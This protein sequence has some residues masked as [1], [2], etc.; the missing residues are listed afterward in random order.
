MSSIEEVGGALADAQASLPMS[1]VLSAM[2]TLRAVESRYADLLETAT[3]EPSNDIRLDLQRA[4]QALIEAREALHGVSENTTHYMA[5]LGLQVTVDPV[6]F[7]GNHASERFPA[8]QET[9]PV[10]HLPTF[11]ELNGGPHV[12]AR[13]QINDMLLALA[14]SDL[15]M[16]EVKRA[17]VATNQV[18]WEAA[19]PDYNPLFI[20][21]PRGHSRARKPDDY[22]DPADPRTID[23]FTTISGEPVV[24]D[25]DG[26]PRNPAGRTGIAGR[27][28]LNKWAENPAADLIVTRENPETGEI[29]AVAIQRKDTGEWGIP[30]GKVGEG[31]SP[32]AA[33]LREF[34]EEAG[35]RG[36]TAAVVADPWGLDMSRARVIY[37]GY[38]DDSRNTDNAWMASTVYHR[39]LTPA[40]AERFVLQAS[41]D[42]R[43]ARWVPVHARFFASHGLL[44]RHAVRTYS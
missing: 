3:A 6:P 21:I 23:S 44:V 4:M 10:N 2:E 40:E 31:E 7:P 35:G 14:Q 39:H 13:T 18:S 22:P 5:A 8:R 26:R 24:R 29:E 12:V 42:A 11:E 28:I 37:A 38:I 1:L 20:D 15:G 30:G 36:D 19:A 41:S 16:R 17:P 32:A 27:G 34:Y 43:A 25:T 33:A 9:L